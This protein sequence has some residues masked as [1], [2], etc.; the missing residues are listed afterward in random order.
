MLQKQ[1]GH[2]PMGHV[3]LAP[4]VSP[5]R[6]R[7]GAHYANSHILIAQTASASPTQDDSRSASAMLLRSHQ[8]GGGATTASSNR[9]PPLAGSPPRP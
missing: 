7:R 2:N 9:S 8:K 6:P 1:A 3:I 5:V 4:G